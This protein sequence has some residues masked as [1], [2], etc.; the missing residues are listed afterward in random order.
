M[1]AGQQAQATSPAAAA[2]PAPQAAAPSRQALPAVDHVLAQVR[3]TLAIEKAQHRQAAAQ[4]AQQAA[5]E[6]ARQT[7]AAATAQAQAQ[8]A[9]L[10]Q[11]PIAPQASPAAGGAKADEAAAGNQA[12]PQQEPAVS[13]RHTGAWL[14]SSDCLTTAQLPDCVHTL[15]P[16]LCPTLPAGGSCSPSGEAGAR[17]PAGADR[18]HSARR[19]GGCPSGG[20]AS[21]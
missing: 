9:A 11:A 10:A 7:D 21:N 3:H 5:A 2:A 15:T 1:P 20:P 6:M 4:K 19:Q 13:G 16:A 12:A 14:P 18:G 17:Q 8:A